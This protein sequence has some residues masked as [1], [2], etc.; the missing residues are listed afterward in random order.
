M[1]KH[2]IDAYK[3]HGEEPEWQ[4]LKNATCRFKQ[5][6]KPTVVGPP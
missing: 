6:H 3:M 4:L 1:W 2:H 5:I